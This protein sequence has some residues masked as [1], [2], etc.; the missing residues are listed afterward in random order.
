MSALNVSEFWKTGREAAVS[1][2]NLHKAYA[3]GGRDTKRK[4][5]MFNNKLM[6][7]QWL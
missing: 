1:E 5:E 7:A 2:I 4:K 6:Y 3:L